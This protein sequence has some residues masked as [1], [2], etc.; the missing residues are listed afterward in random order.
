MADDDDRLVVQLFKYL[1]QILKAP[2]VDTRLRL[3]EQEY[4]AAL[5]DRRSEFDA[6]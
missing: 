4:F 3:V 1:D 6:L 2:Q 5:G